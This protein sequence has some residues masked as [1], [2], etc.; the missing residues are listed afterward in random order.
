[1]LIFDSINVDLVAI[2]AVNAAGKGYAGFTGRTGF[3]F[4]SHDV[5]RWLLTEGAPSTGVAPLVLKSHSFNF[6][7]DQLTLT[8]GSSDTKTYRI[9][10]SS[11]L[12]PP[13]VTIASGIAGAPAQNETSTTVNFT[14][15]T[16][17]FFRVEQE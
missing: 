1:M 15:G 14:Q 4:E 7:T 6:V 10:T 11:N 16:R 3:H 2:G 9:T 8:W 5:T 13:W 17:A 12:A